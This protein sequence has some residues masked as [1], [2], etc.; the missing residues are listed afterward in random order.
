[1]SRT[2]FLLLIFFRFSAT[3]L[4]LQEFKQQQTNKENEQNQAKMLSKV[5]RT[6]KRGQ[7][8][9]GGATSPCQLGQNLIIRILKKIDLRDF[10]CEILLL[11]LLVVACLEL[12]TDFQP[13]NQPSSSITQ[14]EIACSF[15]YMFI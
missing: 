7:V 1:M 15:H 5:N 8:W 14:H 12:F 10:E 13:R 11:A 2:H 4:A 6:R 9:V 3:I